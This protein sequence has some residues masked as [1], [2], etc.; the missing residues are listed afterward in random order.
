MPFSPEEELEG[1]QIDVQHLTELF[2][3][4]VVFM[5]FPQLA[6]EVTVCSPH[7]WKCIANGK[8]ETL[9]LGFLSPNFVGFCLFLPMLILTYP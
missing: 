7:V 6:C 3:I 9:N 2:H 1:S 4:T 8:A 5:D